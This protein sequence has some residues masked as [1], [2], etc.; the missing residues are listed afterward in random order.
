MST[1][2]ATASCDPGA[3]A[4][5]AMQAIES[6][7]SE[8]KNK[9]KTVD[10]NTNNNTLNQQSISIAR[11]FLIKASPKFL[12]SPISSD[13]D[14]L[15]KVGRSISDLVRFD[16]DQSGQDAA[17]ETKDGYV[18]VEGEKDNS[19]VQGLSHV[20]QSCDI[21]SEIPN[22]ILKIPKVRFG[23][24]ELQMPIVTLGT[25]RFQ[26]SWGQQIK[27]MD[28]INARGQENL[29]AI[30]RH[31]IYNLGMNHVECARGY[32]SSELQVGAALQKLYSEGIVK[33][34]DLIIQTKV[35]A[36]NVT[37]FRDTLEKSFA[38]LQVDYVD[39]FSFH[40][41]NLQYHY[42]LIFNNP[43]GENL[44]DIA[45]EYQAKGKIRH[46]GFS[47][48]AQPCFIRKCIETEVFEYANVHYHAFGSYTASGGGEFGG[49][50]DIIRLM[51]EKDM[52]VFVI[53]PYDKGGR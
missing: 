8:F 37:D 38:T 6:A 47:S 29:L 31:S 53:S 10:P 17:L 30:M 50:K 14:R 33:R 13:D 51:K 46:I 22:G 43:N 5:W 44:I 52:G 34:E 4:E 16:K 15:V 2:T 32:G 26:Q 11:H 18:L 19:L 9:P 23:S 45:K 20:V 3:L 41:L 42:D 7:E 27:D 1:S 24:T 25:M 35:G 49:N 39:L 48:H 28:E 40:G 12:Q 21:L 36:M